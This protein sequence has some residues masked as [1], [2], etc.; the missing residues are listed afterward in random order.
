[1]A[2]PYH[3]NLVYQKHCQADFSENPAVCRIRTAV[4]YRRATG[5]RVAQIH[6]SISD[7]TKTD[8]SFRTVRVA[9]L[10]L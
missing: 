3:K 7:R 10:I 1:M 8:L 9:N 5:S 6:S 2:N 4:S